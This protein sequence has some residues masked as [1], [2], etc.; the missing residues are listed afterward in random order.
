MSN[1]Q[2]VEN[3]ID[4]A[5]EKDLPKATEAETPP[6]TLKCT[7]QWSEY[8]KRWVY[9]PQDPAYFRSMYYK[10]KYN[11]TCDICGTVITTKLS[12]HF[13]TGKCRLV[14]VALTKMI[15]EIEN[16]RDD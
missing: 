7:K 12:K 1:E 16:E 14:Q 5:I 10:Y 11:K 9:I 2:N 15:K 6:P 3:N 13:K 4:R 8:Q